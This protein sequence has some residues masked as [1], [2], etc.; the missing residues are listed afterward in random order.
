VT[1]RHGPPLEP[2]LFV[3]DLGSASKHRFAV[4]PVPVPEEGQEIA[5]FN[6]YVRAHLA[7]PE[8]PQ[9]QSVKLTVPL[10]KA[11]EPFNLATFIHDNPDATLEQLTEAMAKTSTTE[12]EI[13]PELEGHPLVKATILAITGREASLFELQQTPQGGGQGLAPYQPPKTSGI[14][15]GQMVEVLQDGAW[16]RA[17][18]VHHM[19]NGNHY[20]RIN[21]N[22]HVEVADNAIRPPQG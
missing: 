21:N 6:R 15:P 19:P 16:H 5:K 7:I 14:R 20:A 1:W 12:L 9:L 10:T 13:P 18:Y 17:I 22:W 11:P 2:G 3:L 8:P 4:V